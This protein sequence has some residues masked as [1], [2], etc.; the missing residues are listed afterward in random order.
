MRWR[1]KQ[2]ELDLD[3]EL[4]THLDLEAA[5]Q[6]EA[7]LSADQA[8][9]AARRHLGNTALLR[10]AVREVWG[11][12]ALERIGQDVRYGLRVL[13]KNQGFSVVAVLALALGIGASTTVFSV[14]NSVLLN[15]FPYQNPD[16]LVVIETTDPSGRTAG[17]APANFLDWRKKAQS[18]SYLAAKL[19]WTA[20]DLTGPEGNEQI[21]GAPVSAGMF[22]ALGLKSALGRTFLPEDDG[23]EA[24]PTVILSDRLWKHRYSRSQGILGRH[25]LVSGISRTVIGVMPAGVYL[26][27][28]GYGTTGHVDELWVPL[29]SQL[30]TEVMNW[31]DSSNLRVFARLRPGV[32]RGQ[33]TAEMQQINASLQ[34]LYPK[35]NAARGVMVKPLAEFRAD[36]IRTPRQITFILF[37]VVSLVLL[38]GCANVAGLQ[39]ARA[40]SRQREIALR[41][42]LGAGRFRILEQLLTESALLGLLGGTLGL[43]LAV[44]GT[45][46]IKTFLPDNVPLP[47]VNELGIDHRVLAYSLVV[48]LLA[49]LL[50]GIFPARHG[51]AWG[52]PNGLSEALRSSGSN[53]AGD[54]GIG[55]FRRYLMGAQVAVTLALLFGS[56]L[57]IRSFLSLRGVSPGFAQDHLLTIRM[58]APD[59]SSAVLE[60]KQYRQRRSRFVESVLEQA[61]QLPGVAA[62]AFANGRPASG[63]LF[64]KPFLVD[65]TS[66]PGSAINRIVT[67]DYFRTLDIPARAGR[68]FQPSDMETAPLV[69]VIDTALVE[70]YFGDENPIGKR[71]RWHD[72]T[73]WATVVGVVEKIRD[74]DLRLSPRP[75]IYFS[76]FQVNNSSLKT[77]LL[78]RASVNSQALVPRVRQVIQDL[79]PDQPIGEIATMRESLYR[80]ATPERFNAVL[81][82]SFAATALFLAVI[83]IYGVVSYCVTGRTHEIGIRMALGASRRTVLQAVLRRE[84][85]AVWMGL[86]AGVLIALSGGRVLGSMLYDVS[87]MDPLTFVGVACVL[88]AAALL[89]SCIPAW[90]AIRVDPWVALRYE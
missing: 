4:R 52:V 69:A 53:V 26:N 43:G 80:A 51:L 39:L 87:P 32:S 37:G 63:D 40:A 38:V 45:T 31:R 28:D 84:M 67:P 73:T 57:L 17:V 90:R 12:T 77:T 34:R 48:S 58:P 64:E 62:V 24:E 47:R 85:A 72:T 5:E 89:A 54:R 23:P 21:I 79:K 60:S 78:I 14:L 18:F 9:F 56:G 71:I 41:L 55:G 22:E 44:Y 49:G 27:R 8:Q 30:S 13:H 15:R 16:R 66:R 70:Q 10:E 35:E 19:D 83:G 74:N 76:W 50:T 86:L 3:R 46:L 2:R 59:V 65:G 81:L 68:T 61:A 29:R 88:L 42:S 25:I 20:H 82:A 11:W 7:G 1:R 6:R 36:R 75:E 33:A